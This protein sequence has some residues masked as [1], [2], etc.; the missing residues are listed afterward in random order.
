MKTSRAAPVPQRGVSVSHMLLDS[1]V[2][3]GWAKNQ[4]EEQDALLLEK[5]LERG[6]LHL[7]AFARHELKRMVAQFPTHPR[8]GAVNIL[9]EALGRP[10]PARVEEAVEHANLMLEPLFRHGT[11]PGV[12]DLFI[13]AEADAL[14]EP[15]ATSD[16]QL[17]EWLRRFRP[18]PSAVWLI[19]M[20]SAPGGSSRGPS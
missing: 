14:D 17:A 16:A 20:R 8:N 9:I 12:F 3:V 7:G 15:L 19:A 5:L 1:S 18:E 4:F 10:S 2:V 13:G 6:D 11:P